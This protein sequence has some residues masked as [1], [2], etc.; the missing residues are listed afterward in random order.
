MN[1]AKKFR[2][3]YYFFLMKFFARRKNGLA[4]ER[5]V[6]LAGYRD[7]QRF[8]AIVDIIFPRTRTLRGHYL[9][10]NYFS[11]Y[12]ATKEKIFLYSD[13]TFIIYAERD[14]GS[15]SPGREG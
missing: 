14:G 3:F 2:I 4:G 12:G 15:L 1:N 8:D 9:K 7:S 6:T 5:A 13:L 10:W 11:H